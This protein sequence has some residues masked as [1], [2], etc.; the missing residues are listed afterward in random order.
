MHGLGEAQPD[1]AI[2]AMAAALV[3]HTTDA[4]IAVDGDYAVTLWSPGAEALY[5]FSAEEAL[6]RDARTLAR[7]DPFDA[8]RDAVYDELMLT[9]STRA[10][11]RARHKDGS[12]VEVEVVAVALPDAPDGPGG[13]VGIHRDLSDRRERERLS[14]RL[15]QLAV[16]APDP[17]ADAEPTLGAATILEDITDAFCALDRDWRITY[18]NAKALALASQLAGEELTREDVLGTSLWELLPATVGTNLD[19]ECRRAVDERRAA[20]FEFRWAEDGPWFEIHAY[21]AARGLSIYF[22]EISDRKLAEAERERREAQHELVAELGL[23]ALSSD[24]LQAFVDEVALRVARALDVEVVSVA[25]VLPGR[26]RLVLRAG[27]GW[28]DGAVGTATGG[29]GRDSFAGYAIMTGEPVVSEDLGRDPRFTRVALIAERGADVAAAV[30]IGGGDEPFGV[31]AVFADHPRRISSEDVNFLQAVANVM[32]TAVQRVASEHRFQEVREAERGRIARDLHDEA[33]QDLTH[34]LVLAE[35]SVSGHGVEARRARADVAPRLEAVGRH[36]RG[37]IYDLRLGGDEHRPF[38]ELLD[39]LI[40]VHRSMSGHPIE[41]STRELPA[42]SL[43]RTGTSVLRILGEALTNARRHADATQVR[44]RVWLSGDALCADVGDDGRG[45]DPEVPLSPT[46]G[47]GLA[48]M[49]ER[50]ALLGARLDVDAAPGR[51]TR[52]RLR[53]PLRGDAEG[54][55]GPVRI[56]LVE[57]HAAVRESMAAAFALHVGFEVVGQAASMAQARAMLQDLDVDVA[58]VDLGLPDGY[59]ADLIPELRDANPQAQA[60]VLSA[61]LER[62]DI[63]KAVARGAAGALHKTAR[64]HEIVAAVERLRAGETLMPMEEIVELLRLAGRE[65]ERELADRAAIE[66]LTPRELEVLQALAEGLNSQQ[67]A[68]RLFISVRTQRNHVANILAKLGVHSQV[69][70]LVFALRH[71]LVAPR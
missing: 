28:P 5:G 32:A 44:A 46:G 69:Q 27:V 53:V 33:L 8:H 29:I 59:G 63:A 1:A 48:G 35:R 24:E 34:A 13:F 57:D 4:I 6:G 71:G 19:D 30:V 18:S 42:G 41:L 68:N 62:S 25:E 22:R 26:D 58:I 37:A 20:I 40:D 9:G 49:A 39:G 52:I 45:F 67:A 65:R 12:P 36:L 11:L 23:R 60:L 3:A 64:L 70:A 14:R 55:P 38:A 17:V 7:L 16:A 31:L 10:E 50:A 15:A 56:M 2:A 51:G 21:P 43:G 54:S 61:T 66:S 47:R